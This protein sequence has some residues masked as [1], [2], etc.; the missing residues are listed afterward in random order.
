[1]SVAVDDASQNLPAIEDE[2]PRFPGLQHQDGKNGLSI[3][4]RPEFYAVAKEL[5]GSQV[6]WG[7]AV[8]LQQ[9]VYLTATRSDLQAYRKE[10]MA[11]V[12]G[13]EN[14]DGCKPPAGGLQA[15]C[16]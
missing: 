16:S 8:L 7:V 5:C 14:K 3:A 13:A 6:S 10:S 9:L 1:M 11:G 12:D 2:A 15:P 4:F